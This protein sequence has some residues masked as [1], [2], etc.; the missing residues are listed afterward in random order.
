[1]FERVVHICVGALVAV[2]PCELVF[3]GF[4]LAHIA[5]GVR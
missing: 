3:I 2:V 5:G 4:A 1:M